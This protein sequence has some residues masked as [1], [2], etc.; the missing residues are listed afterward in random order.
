MALVIPV[1]ILLLTTAIFAIYCFKKRA[2]RAEETNRQ[3]V[4]RLPD[5][6]QVPP[7]SNSTNNAPGNSIGSIYR[8][9]ITPGLIAKNLKYMIDLYQQSSVTH[10]DL[11]MIASYYSFRYRNCSEEKSFFGSKIKSKIPK[12]SQQH[13]GWN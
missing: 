12:K 3:L 4:D 7:Q 10:N 8:S 9:D 2:D 5:F 6:N 11:L 13:F 1:V